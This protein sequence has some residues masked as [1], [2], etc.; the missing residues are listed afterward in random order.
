MSSTTAL[1]LFSV[2]IA[3]YQNGQYIDEALRSLSAQ[4]CENWEAVVVDDASSDNSREVLAAWASEPR[5]KIVIHESNLGA[6]AAFA[7][8]AANATGSIMGMLGADDALKPNAIERMLQAHA[9]R[10]DA[11]LINSDLVVCDEYL[12]PLGTRSPYHAPSSGVSLIRDCPISSFATFKRSA[13]DRTAG[14]DRSLRRAVD[15][16]IY[17]KLEEVGWLG[18][19]AEP[20]YLYRAHPGGISQGDNGMLAAQSALI[21]RGNAYR[22]RRGKTIPN[23]TRQE[24]RA[25]LSTFHRRETQIGSTGARRARIYMRE[26]AGGVTTSMLRWV[27]HLSKDAAVSIVLIRDE[28]RPFVPIESSLPALRQ[29]VEFNGLLDN[30]RLVYARCAEGIEQSE[31]LIA[32]DIVELGMISS[33]RLRNPV[34]FVLHGDYDYYYQL[35]LSHS[36]QIGSFLCV[37]K[38]VRDELLR[39]LPL[40]ESDIHLTYPIVPESSLER[41]AADHGTPLR[42]LFVGRLTE[43]KGFPDLPSIDTELTSSGID[44][45]W[46]V[47][48]AH[49][50]DVAP[51]AETWLSN[52]RVTHLERVPQHDMDAIYARH[53]VLVFPSRFEGFGMTVL[54][55]MKAGVVPVASRLLAGIPEMIDDGVSGFMTPAGDW[56]AMSANIAELARDPSRL[57]TMSAAARA[58][59]CERFDS[60]ACADRMSSAIF[61]ASVRSADIGDAPDYLSRLDRGWIPN[62]VVRTTRSLLRSLRRQS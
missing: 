19:V 31:Y 13:Y 34:A 51:A 6:G 43:E 49:Y 20:L 53:D 50:G 8:A 10:P 32:N 11:S 42:L 59:A 61:A 14:F 25:L 16:D 58:N 54:E 33:L 2:L 12:E 23:L 27:A 9:E 57:A 37:S 22:R 52:D 40:R 38:R 18:Y 1:P 44:V 21:A 35:A 56:R 55:A 26:M 28:T 46:T 36:S 5:I 17:L 24:Y 30:K 15:H 7:T 29:H 45:R 47:V 4:T 62:Q 41:S 60:D 39:R 48:A 3:N